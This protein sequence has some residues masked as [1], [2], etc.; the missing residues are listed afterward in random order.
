MGFSS[1]LSWGQWGWGGS[2]EEGWI[3]PKSPRTSRPAPTTFCGP[4][5]VGR[6]GVEGSSWA[7]GSYKPATGISEAEKNICLGRENG[8]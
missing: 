5:R 6:W 8:K 1:Q 4:R 2:R 3:S 7:L